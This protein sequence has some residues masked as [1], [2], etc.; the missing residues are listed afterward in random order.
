MDGKALMRIWSLCMDGIAK[1]ARAL[2]VSNASKKPHI[3]LAKRWTYVLGPRGAI[4][5]DKQALDKA[6]RRLDERRHPLPMA[7]R[8]NT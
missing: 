1:A 6:I 5:R 4:D 3:Y 8:A 2:D 7:Q